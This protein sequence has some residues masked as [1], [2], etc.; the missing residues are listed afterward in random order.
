MAGRLGRAKV[1]TRLLLLVLAAVI[2]MATIAVMGAL[3]ARSTIEEEQRSQAK[4][5]VESALGVIAHYGELESAG[6]MTREAAQAAAAAAIREMRYSGEEYFWIND[7]APTMVMHPIKPE[8]DGTDLSANADPNGKKLFV[9][10]VETVEAQGSGYVDYLW[11]KPGE[12]EPQP[13]VSY[14]TGY[15]PW[16]WVVGSGLYVADL[17]G[18]FRAELVT[19]ALWAAPLILGIVVLS[20]L[21]SRSINRPL[22]EMTEVL[23]TGDLQ[24]RLDEGAGRTEL[25]QLA[26]AV[27][28]TLCRVSGVVADV[29]DA[30]RMLEDAARTLSSTSECIAGTAERSQGQAESVTTAAREVSSGI[31]AVAAGAEQMGASIREIAHNAAEAARI[32]GSAVTAAE[33]TSVTIGRLGESSAEIGNVV[34][35]ITSIAEQTNLLALNATIEAAR[36]GEAGKGFAVVANEV[37]ELAQ[38]TAKATEDIARRVEAIQTDT[39]S[40]VQAIGGV[41]T[42]IAEINDYQTTIAS[43][44][45]EQTATTNEMSRAIADAAQSGR[46]IA[47]TVA[48]VATGAQE[49]SAGVADMQSAADDLVR[50][51]AELQKVAGTFE[52]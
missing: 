35:V 17:D 19:M 49:T 16:G 48:E 28:T 37:K 15:E 6:T 41:T 13:K 22:R 14:V 50:M 33:S 18:A 40:A 4:V 36:A 3:Q 39:G 44:V 42:I 27:N 26:G 43:A 47:G 21:I 30:S 24:R 45:E 20:L 10:F 8:L 11:P 25:D 34:K 46:S 9:E 38:E 52:Q 23:R 51:S 7:M 2:G 29:G 5:A 12:E 1:S 31:E 32:A